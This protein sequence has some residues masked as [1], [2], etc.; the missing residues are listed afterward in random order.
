[1]AS[2]AGKIAG[3]GLN[4]FAAGLQ[5]KAQ[6]AADKENS[7]TQQLQRRMAFNRDTEAFLNNAALVR[8]QQT[9][10]TLNLAL[11]GQKV[12]DELAIGMAGSGISGQSVS[13]LQA[14]VTRSMALDK[15]AIDRAAAG[16]LDS[17]RAALRD[18]NENRLMEARMART[19]DY[20]QGIQSA[21]FSSIGSALMV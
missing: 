10:D 3:I 12:E 16:N 19:S 1:M 15:V 9:L 11:A 5:A 20:H 13:E 17:A 2:P 6:Y 14:D 21:M 18:R 8:Q 7:K 4:M